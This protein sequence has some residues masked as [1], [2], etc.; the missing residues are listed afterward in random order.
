MENSFIQKSSRLFKDT[1]FRTLFSDSK[2]F[3]E[4]YNGNQKLD[5]NVIKLSDSFRVKQ[6]KPA[7]ELVAEVIDINLNSGETAL[8]R[9]TTLQNYSYLIEEVRKNQA[10]GMSRDKAIV[11]A[12]DLCIGSEILSEFLIEHYTEVLKMLSWEY[13]ADAEKRVLREEGAELLAK[14]IKDGVPVDEAIKQIKNENI[15]Q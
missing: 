11:T 7:M 12:I 3:L 15:P 6:S 14:L 8:N 10:N 9:S 4:L 13:D 2:S 5:S 1:L